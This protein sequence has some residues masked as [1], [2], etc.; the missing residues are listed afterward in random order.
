MEE[1]I[2]ALEFV[3]EVFPGVLI[4]AHDG[5]LSCNQSLL[6]AASHVALR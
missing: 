1:K 5:F 6:T 3:E 4:A 2:Y